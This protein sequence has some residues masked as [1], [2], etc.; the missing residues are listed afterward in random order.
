MQYSIRKGDSQRSLKVPA[1]Q[2][3]KTVE[4]KPKPFIMP[5]MNFKQQQSE[6]SM[7]QTLMNDI[8]K[9]KHQPKRD[10]NY[11]RFM[12][13]FT[14]DDLYKDD[15][16]DIAESIHQRLIRK[17]QRSIITFNSE[18]CLSL[19]I[20]KYKQYQASIMLD[21]MSIVTVNKAA[22]PT[23]TQRRAQ[24]ARKSQIM[25]DSSQIKPFHPFKSQFILENSMDSESIDN[26]SH[27]CKPILRAHR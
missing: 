26:F 12:E 11:T 9:T 10:L 27:R 25:V 4:V 2:E 23:P 22:Q 8:F 24:N 19:T 5:R 17:R 20:E 14:I 6:S 18:G 21:A 15:F 3:N 7:W 16:D 13:Y 1:E